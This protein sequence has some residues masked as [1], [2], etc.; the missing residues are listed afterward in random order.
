VATIVK[1]GAIIAKF[2]S[3]GGFFKEFLPIIILTAALNGLI[4]QIL[5]FWPGRMLVQEPG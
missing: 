2:G 4:V 5:A 1:Y 3:F